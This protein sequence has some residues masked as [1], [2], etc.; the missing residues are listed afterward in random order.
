MISRAFSLQNH[1][2][3]VL[4]WFCSERALF[5]IELDS[6]KSTFIVVFS[7]RQLPDFLKQVTLKD[8]VVGKNYAAKI[9][10]ATKNDTSSKLYM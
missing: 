7:T 4:E 3:T 8:V 2:R 9:N 10:Y 5:I 1:S 6:L